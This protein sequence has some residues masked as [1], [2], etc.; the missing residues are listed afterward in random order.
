MTTKFSQAD[1]EQMLA[2]G[3]SEDA[4]SEQLLNFKN[5]FPHISL[6]APATVENGGIVSLS[7]QQQKHFADIFE[8]ERPNK[9][10]LKF[11][12][13]SGAAS[14]MFKDLAAFSSQYFGV[15][16]N[17][18]KEYAPVK[19][20]FDNLEKFP[21]YGELVETMEK[22]GMDI[23]DYLERK[24]FATIVNCLLSKKF[25]GYSSLP[26]A[27][28]KFH[29]YDGDS[30][31]CIIEHFTEGVRYAK[32]KGKNINLHF[33][34][35]P[36]HREDFE[37]TI[38]DLKKIYSESFDITLSEQ[39]HYTDTIAVDEYNEPL[40]DDDGR[41][42]FRPGG[43]GALLE[44]LNECSADI[45]F[46]KNIDNVTPDNP[47]L[48][49]KEP[50]SAF[51]KKVLGGMLIELQNTCFEY[52]RL[53]EGTVSEDH[54]EEIMEFAKKRLNI[55]FPDGFEALDT[56]G[57]KAF[58]QN[59]FSR[60]LRVCGMVKNEGEPG[61]GPFWV[62]DVEGSISLQIVET[63]QI[64]RK[65]P[66]Q[67][68]ILNGSTHFNP[69]DIV[70]STRDYKNRQFDLRMYRDPSTGFITN[71]TQGAKTLKS[72]ELPGL[73]NGSMARWNTVFVEVPL[74]TFNPV[75]TVNDLLKDVH[76]N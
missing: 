10:I 61:G 25:M 21:F 30:Y 59:R 66:H 64:N 17:F 49:G 8:A 46:I 28:I 44:N 35:S 56:D 43:H 48:M 32:G 67:E 62:N 55:S 29:K 57:K 4:I 1:I 52:M 20:F 41:L 47:F 70:C 15:C 76:Q 50:K 16:Y 2:L 36:E 65:D 75:K 42:V 19:V 34:V 37:R 3:I 7:A 68:S 5:K 9:K 31:P 24:D 71:K 53:M 63:N 39:K 14:R 73:W 12:P 40:R 69:V 54:V 38:K 51:Y 23:R 58:L 6:A 13:A 72:Q 60:P 22:S 18:E 33:T 11:V 45:I 74:L 26:K 27:L